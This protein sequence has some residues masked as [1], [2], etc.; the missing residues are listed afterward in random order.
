M[1][2]L[3]GWPAVYLT[4][5]LQFLQIE[6]K[7]G[8]RGFDYVAVQ[9]VGEGIA[10]PGSAAVAEVSAASALRIH[11]G[12]WVWLKSKRSVIRPAATITAFNVI[13]AQTQL[14]AISVH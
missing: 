11:I 2:I 6:W 7:T 1:S 8:G 4:C 3:R 14:K 10:S 13:A 12:H 5:T 9:D